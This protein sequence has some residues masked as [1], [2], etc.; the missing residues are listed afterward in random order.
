MD[1]PLVFT[2]DENQEYYF[3]EGCFILEILNTEADPDI[4]IARARVAP[5]TSTRF[6][7]LKGTS[8][9]YLIQQ[10]SGRVTI[11]DQ[12]PVV[13]QSGSVVLI[14][15]GARQ[16]IENIGSEA[17][18]FLAICTPRFSPECYLDDSNSHQGI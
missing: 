17:L 12:A 1:Q 3:Q 14:P 13:V 4:S 16:R 11:A 5:G 7:R 2:S 8:E 9:R 15:P 18:V 6:H 10:G